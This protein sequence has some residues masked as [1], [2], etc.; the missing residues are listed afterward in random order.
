MLPYDA[1]HAAQ[2]AY[3]PCTD[4]AIAHFNRW[5]QKARQAG[6]EIDDYFRVLWKYSK[7]AEEKRIVDFVERMKAE[8]KQHDLFLDLSKLMAFDAGCVER[9]EALFSEAREVAERYDLELRLPE[10]VPRENR[11]CHFVEDGGAFVSWEGDVHPCYFLWRNN[12]V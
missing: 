1:Q 12:F 10:A 3:P 2:A 7:T 5:R 6:V 9:L 8:A 4:A 11:L